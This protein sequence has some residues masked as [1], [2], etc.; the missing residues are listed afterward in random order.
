MHLTNTKI[1]DGGKHINTLLEKTGTFE[2]S[3][4]V[5]IFYRHYQAEPER[6]RLVIAHG[7]GEHSGRYGN[8]IERMLPMGISVWAPD[9]RGHGQSEGKRGHVLNFMQYLTDMRSMIELAR[10]GLDDDN[11]CFLMGHSLGGLIA[12]YFAQRF[13]E[14]VDG[15]VASSPVL[16][17]IIEIPAAK[18]ILGSLM[19][20][21]WPGL[22]MGNELDTG[23]ISHDPEVVNAYNNDPL[24]HDRVS[25]RFFAEFMAAMETVNQQAPSLQVPILMQVAG[26]DHL[27]NA[28][29][30][31]Q[32]FEKLAVPDKTLHVYEGLYHEIYNEPAGQR[33]KVLKNLEDWLGERI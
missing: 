12:I 30:A 3:D 4:G 32:F 19:S 18:K 33:E 11:K 21:L 25:I 26:D 23:K 14:I 20:F 7:L 8:V 17:R 29:T 13:P 6:A 9:H 15:I 16:G 10:D 31:E 22:T 5:D 1:P 2:G 27:V 28:R 24:A